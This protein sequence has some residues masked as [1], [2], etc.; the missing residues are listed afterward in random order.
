MQRDVDIL[1][2]QASKHRRDFRGEFLRDLDSD[3]IGLVILGDRLDALGAIEIVEPRAA[4][5]RFHRAVMERDI[6]ALEGLQAPCSGRRQINREEADLELSRDDADRNSGGAQGA[7]LGVVEFARSARPTLPAM[8]ARG[9]KI[10][11]GQ[12]LRGHEKIPKN[13]RCEPWKE[14]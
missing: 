11:R 5:R 2:D 3:L 8:T 7:G 13:Q 12:G 4:E 6:H 14:I 1:L 10:R 9:D